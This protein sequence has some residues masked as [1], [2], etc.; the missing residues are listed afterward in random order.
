MRIKINTS[1][2][3]AEVLDRNDKSIA[4]IKYENYEF[5][6]D[7][8]RLIDEIKATFQEINSIG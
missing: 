6:G 5:D 1:K 3:E 2:F 4:H 7:T 8:V